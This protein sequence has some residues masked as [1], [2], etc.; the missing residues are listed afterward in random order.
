MR[1]TI[2]EPCII[3]YEG[4]LTVTPI[5]VPAPAITE[6]EYW[7]QKQ[8]DVPAETKVE[9]V[10]RVNS[11]PKN[12]KTRRRHQVGPCLYCGEMFRGQENQ[13]Y[14]SSVHKHRYYV[15]NPSVPGKRRIKGRVPGPEPLTI[16]AGATGLQTSADRA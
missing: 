16:R 9:Y 13:L 7:L 12:R 8:A 2:M 1:I 14:C 3:E 5:P 11:Y 6:A 10:E 15:Q 4:T